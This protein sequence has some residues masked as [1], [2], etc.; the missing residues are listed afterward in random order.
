MRADV[1]E[2]V[3][4]DAG[5]P[6]LAGSAVH[7]GNHAVRSDPLGAA[8]RKSVDALTKAGIAPEMKN[9]GLAI[10]ASLVARE[11]SYQS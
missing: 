6:A 7:A 1:P 4:Y 11:R 8:I 2:E 10:V 5:A 3:H 9:T